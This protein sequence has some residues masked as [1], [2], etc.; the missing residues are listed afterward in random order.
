MWEAI[1]SSYSRKQVYTDEY[2]VYASL[3]PYSRHWVCPK[4]SGDTN[5][6]E[7]VNNAFRHRVS[8][9]VRKSSSFARNILW[10]LRR[11]HFFSWQH[12]QRM[13]ERLRNE[14]KNHSQTTG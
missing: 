1:P 11:L 10:L 14:T 7:G 2:A 6:V 4:G 9:L 12:N 5:I 8:Y 3:I 13:A